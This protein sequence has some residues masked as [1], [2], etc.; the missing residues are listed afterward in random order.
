MTAANM[1][2][3]G[4]SGFLYSKLANM[5]EKYSICDLYFSTPAATTN[6]TLITNLT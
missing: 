1:Q 5:Q 4:D 6:E 3:L 2:S